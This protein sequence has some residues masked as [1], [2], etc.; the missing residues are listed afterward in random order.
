MEQKNSTKTKIL[1]IAENSFAQFGFDGTSMRD[2]IIEAKVNNAAIFYHFG[3]K[4]SL[5]E[6][7]FNRLATPVVEQ[8]LKLLSSCSKTKNTPMLRQILLSYLKPALKTAFKNNQ[9]RYNFSKI[10]MQLSQKNHP[11]MSEMLS[12]HFT[13][14]GEMFLK[15]LSQ[16]FTGLSIKDI[17]WRYQ[18][19]V[20]ALTFLMG[21]AESIKS[22]TFGNKKEA[23][24]PLNMK[25]AFEHFLPQMELVFL[26]P[27]I[28]SKML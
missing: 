25:E 11:F 27:P 23:Y 15:A 17:Q 5:F 3:S 14:T 20:G 6:A 21:S 24:D 19:M 10:R 4:Q 18:T 16:E 28:N 8:R 1:D 22:G 26:A 13:I 2:I 12:N 7:V 9:Q